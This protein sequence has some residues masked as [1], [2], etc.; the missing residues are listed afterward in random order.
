MKKLM[1]W[2]AILGGSFLAAAFMLVAGLG[3]NRMTAAAETGSASGVP[4]TADSEAGPGHE[5]ILQGNRYKPS[6]LYERAVILNTEASEGADSQEKEILAQIEERCRALLE[7]EGIRVY[8]ISEE[9]KEADPENK[10]LLAEQTKA[11]L[12]LGLTLGG[13]TDTEVFGSY[14]CYNSLYFRP[15]LTNGS[16]ADRM[17]REV[18]TA[19]EGKALGLVE[20][21]EGILTE[22]SIPAAVVC[23][24]YMSNETEKELLLTQAYQERIA[25]GICKGITDTFEE[26]E[27]R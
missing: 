19:I 20:V 1:R 5:L 3:M 24:G 26:L 13:D 22:L 10:M 18:V 21:E 25:E 15:W 9:G 11:G 7:A 27:L 6:E 17:E 12:Y 16:F 4:E 8:S 14:V 2:S 23:P